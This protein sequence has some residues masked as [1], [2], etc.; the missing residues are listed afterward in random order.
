VREAIVVDTVLASRC[1]V[2]MPLRGCAYAGLHG[3]VDAEGEPLA[4]HVGD[5]RG[6]AD[7]L[8]GVVVRLVARWPM[9]EEEL[10]W[11]A[12][13]GSAESASPRPRDGED[14]GGECGAGEAHDWKAERHGSVLS[15]QPQQ[16]NGDQMVQRVFTPARLTAYAR[17]VLLRPRCG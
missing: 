16:S 9:A 11:C 7:G 4:V 12:A 2:V 10:R 1:A 6:H 14:R 15:A 5:Q 17:R 8:L 13:A 3:V